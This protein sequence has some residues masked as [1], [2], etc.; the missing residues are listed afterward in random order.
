M[1][2]INLRDYYP[3]Y[4]EDKIV[5]VPD[6]VAALLEDLDRKEE[7]YLR[8][9]RRYGAFFT[10]DLGDIKEKDMLICGCCG[11]RMTRKINRYKGKEYVYYFCP[12]GKKHGCSNG[13]MVKESDLTECV[14]TA[15]KGHIDN[16][17]SLDLLLSSISHERINRELAREYAG[18]IKSCEKQLEKTESYKS[19]LYENLVNGMLT[20]EEFLSYK[21]KYNA[22]IE[23]M[24]AAI[25]G[26]NEKLTDVL[27]NRSERNRW[28]NHFMKKIP[29]C[30]VL[31][32]DV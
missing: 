14:Q 21:R 25:N 30:I 6:E 31:V 13:V 32:N 5:E 12:T 18:H 15:V 22:D 27:E 24:Q 29:V 1:K 2:Q 10:F 7:S 19:K 3:H 9:L 28:I 4:K 16:I 17:A 20:K 26:W 8:Y 23:S 11:G